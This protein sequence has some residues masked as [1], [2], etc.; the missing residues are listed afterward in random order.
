MS[1]GKKAQILGGLVLLTLG[2]WGV[3]HG[4]Y[5]VWPVFG[6]SS[7]RDTV[8]IVGNYFLDPVSY[9]SPWYASV[10]VNA[11]EKVNFTSLRIGDYEALKAAA[12]DPYVAFRDAY[13]QYRFK[14][15]KARRARIASQFTPEPSTSPEDPVSP[16]KGN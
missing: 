16:E 7:P 15:I 12:I 5:I 4:F 8:S 6:P 13:L 9:L 1:K 2:V 11:F 14:A 10:G 3:G